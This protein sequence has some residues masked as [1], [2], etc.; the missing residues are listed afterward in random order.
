MGKRLVAIEL[1]N[2][3][4]GMHADGAG[5]YLNVQESGS[6]SWILRTVVRGKRTDIGLGGLATT[7]LAK[8]REKATSLREKARKGEDILEACRIEKHVIPTFKEA[9]LTYHAQISETC[10]SEQHSQNWLRSLELYVFPVFGS[11]AVDVIDAA[12]VL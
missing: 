7:S 12:D 10:D 8:A 6:R 9:A 3:P 4:P 5:L 11:R 1:K 2:L